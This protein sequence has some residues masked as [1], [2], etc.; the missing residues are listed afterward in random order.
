M[1]VKGS[2]SAPNR[3]I[4]D[5][6]LALMSNAGVG[7]IARISQRVALSVETGA[8]WLIPHPVVVIAG[9][10]SGTAGIP[11]L[12]LSIGVSVTL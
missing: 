1:H 12:T 11:S 6:T 10:D 2:A 3:A 4:S 5:D 7:A 8:L 9:Q